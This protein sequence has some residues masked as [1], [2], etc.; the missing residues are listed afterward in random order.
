MDTFRSK[1]LAIFEETWLKD[2]LLKAKLQTY[3]QIKQTYD[4]ESYLKANL[5]R[6]QRSSENSS[7]GP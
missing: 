5:S 3:I 1:L 7:P 4:T 2:I 6:S